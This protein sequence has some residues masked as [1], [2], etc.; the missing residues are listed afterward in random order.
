MDRCE[1]LK[2]IGHIYLFVSICVIGSNI[3]KFLWNHPSQC[4]S[5]QNRFNFKFL[6]KNC[7]IGLDFSKYLFFFMSLKIP[8]DKHAFHLVEGFSTIPKVQQKVLQFG[9]VKTWSQFAKTKTFNTY[10]HKDIH[11]VQPYLGL[12]LCLLFALSPLSWSIFEGPLLGTNI[13]N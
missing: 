6:M 4:Y 9:R 8:N 7:C 13:I 12:H 11:K 3:L 5:N 2:V 1:K 10:P